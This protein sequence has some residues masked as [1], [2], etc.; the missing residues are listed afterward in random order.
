MQTAVLSMQ[1][2]VLSMQTIVLLAL[3]FIMFSLGT[4]LRQ[5]D[6]ASVLQDR[7]ALLLA[8]SCHW[9]MLPALGFAIAGISQLPPEL[10]VG[11]VL[12]ASCP[13]GATSNYLSYLARGDVALSVLLTV[14]SG[15]SSVLTLPLYLWLA[16]QLFSG[17]GGHVNIDLPE[18]I[19]SVLLL[20]LLPVSIG[21]ALRHFAARTTERLERVIAIAAALLFCLVIGNAWVQQWRVILHGSAALIFA[22]IVLNATAL[23]GGELMGRRIG[24][25]RA[26]RT[27]LILETGIQNGAFAAGIALYV[28]HQ[29]LLAV[30]AAI[31]SVVMILTGLAVVYLRRRGLGAAT[32]AACFEH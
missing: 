25:N 13:A 27:T 17:P 11:L 8:V 24:L 19:R 16:M 15:L 31:Y 3:A 14:I 7:R 21:M 26:R 5:R 1:T 28:L 22:V 29:P 4:T 18:T 6:F 30:P 20:T 9:V 32:S 2:F 12:I 10:A 23:A